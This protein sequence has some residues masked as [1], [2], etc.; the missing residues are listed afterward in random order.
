M[1]TDPI[2]LLVVDDDE[3][4][5][6]MLSRRLRRKGYEVAVAEDGQ[7]ALEMIRQQP[8]DLV[9]LDIMMP[10]LNGLEVLEILRRDRPA[11]VLPIIM[12]SARDQS[13]DIVRALEL[14]AN[15][16]VTK[17]LDFPVVLARIRTQLELKGAMDQAVELRRSL[18]ERNRQLEAFSARMTR[19]LRAAAR[20]QRAFLPRA[21]PQVA[22]ATF[23]WVFRPCEELAGDGLNV[24]A[25]DEGRVG[26][27][28]LDVSGHGVASA[29][30][31]VTVGHVLAPPPDPATI[32]ARDGR[33]PV[34]PPEV[35]D[36]LNRRF[37]YDS[38]TEQYFT[39][40]YGVLDVAEGRFDYVAAG[41]PGPALLPAGGAPRILHAP[42]YPIGLAE[43]AYPGLHVALGPGDR[44]V[45]YSDGVTEA[46]SP[47][48]ELFGQA[49][50]LEAL[51]RGRSA[52]LGDALTALRQE[53]ESWCDAAGPRDDISLLA[54]EITPRRDDPAAVPGAP[55]EP[56]TSPP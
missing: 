4:N 50:L 27:Y 52:P 39:F 31:S 3:M 36:E 20:V 56:A 43:D 16:Y 32:L 33:G 10:G 21:A 1:P 13:D 55:A 29:L 23:A 35:A 30:L 41:H 17:P 26:L 40:L 28:V 8:F 49:R 11:T 48:G 6:D 45:L 12:A 42:G 53:V 19:D 51:R 9:V 7:R 14:G 44:L 25:L 5:R 37:P 18:A 22:G 34:P 54:A 15:D 47:S 46:M 2:P 38:T 24:F